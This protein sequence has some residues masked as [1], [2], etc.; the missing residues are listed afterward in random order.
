MNEMLTIGE[1]VRRIKMNFSLMLQI[2]ER[3]KQTY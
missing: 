1:Y 2:I 3:L